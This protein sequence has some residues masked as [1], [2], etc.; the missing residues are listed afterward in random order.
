MS[1]SDSL[2]ECS[3]KRL[4]QIKFEYQ[5]YWSSK[6]N[7]GLQVSSFPYYKNSLNLAKVHYYTIEIDNT[8]NLTGGGL[9]AEWL[10]F[11]IIVRDYEL[12]PD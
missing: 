9:L 2:P 6:K 12:Q 11:D 8:L 1:T 4:L 5:T 7:V 3:I 10:T